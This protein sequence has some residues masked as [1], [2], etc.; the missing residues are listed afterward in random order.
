MLLASDCRVQCPEWGAVVDVPWIGEPEDRRAQCPTCGWSITAG[1]YHASFAHRD[2]NGIGAREAFALYVDRFPQLTSY[3]E[4]MM[5]ID[6]LVHAVHT[7]GGLAA[8]NLFEGRPRDVIATL[9]ALAA[10]G[11]VGGT[12]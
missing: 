10:R 2:L 5:S 9:D 1:E 3:G 7:T 4:R 11:A 6:R 8:R 12:S